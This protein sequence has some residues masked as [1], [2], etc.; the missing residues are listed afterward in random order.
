M[1]SIPAEGA[2]RKDVCSFLQMSFF[3]IC[4]QSG[5]VVGAVVNEAPVELQSREWPKPRSSRQESIPAEGAKKTLAFASV[6]LFNPKDWYV[7]AVRR[8]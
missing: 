4:A 6:F 8:M 5:I 1:G 7:I 3:I 2:R